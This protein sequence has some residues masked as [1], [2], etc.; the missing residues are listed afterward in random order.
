MPHALFKRSCP[1]SLRN[2]RAENMHVIKADDPA[3]PI[4]LLCA[5][6]GSAVRTTVLAQFESRWDTAAEVKLLFCKCKQVSS[7]CL[8]VPVQVQVLKCFVCE[9]NTSPNSLSKRLEKSSFIGVGDQVE[10]KHVF[11]FDQLCLKSFNL[12]SDLSPSLE[13]TPLHNSIGV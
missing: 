7:L 4:P 5:P 9:S 13:S 2:G 1:N 10:S 12:I 11:C 8:Q 6:F 3:S